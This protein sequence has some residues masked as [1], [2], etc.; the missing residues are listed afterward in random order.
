MMENWVE[1]QHED[2]LWYPAKLYDRN[3]YHI[4]VTYV[5]I[6]LKEHDQKYHLLDDI[7][8]IK[9]VVK[10]DNKADHTFVVGDE[11]DYKYSAMEEWQTAHIM[12]VQ[13]YYIKLKHRFCHIKKNFV[14]HHVKPKI[15]I[16]PQIFIKPICP[17]F[18]CPV[19]F[20][21]PFE[22]LGTPCCGIFLC[23]DCADQWLQKSTNCMHCKQPLCSGK[24]Q[25]SR[26]AQQKVSGMEV[27]CP[28]KTQ[29]CTVICTLGV[30]A[31]TLESHLKKCVHADKEC[32]DCGT[33]YSPKEDH[34]CPERLYQC[35]GCMNFI[36]HSSLET[37]FALKSEEAILCAGQIAC[38]YE[39]GSFFTNLKDLL[40]HE[41]RACDKKQITCGHCLQTFKSS[42]YFNHLCRCPVCKKTLPLNEYETHLQQNAVHHVESLMAKI[43]KM[44]IQEKPNKSFLKQ[45]VSSQAKKVNK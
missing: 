19:C 42:E 1:V 38:M 10:D 24:L 41:S 13:G 37:H 6:D 14:R 35:P 27:P 25:V 30:N 28:N 9:S 8:L 12:A 43:A 31:E 34:L 15:K 44:N 36:P 39:C 16:D 33:C 2:G 26:Y 4:Y 32:R 29:G 40:E 11:V 20:E 18:V 5:S 22:P 23:R 17:D 7:H 45:T 21:V 3:L